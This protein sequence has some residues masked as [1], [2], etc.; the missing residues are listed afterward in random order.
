[1]PRDW[2]PGPYDLIVLSEVLY[3]LDRADL[4]SL[5]RLV[6]GSLRAD[7]AVLL[8]NWTGATDTPTTGDEA[9]QAFIG[10]V[11]PRLVV[12]LQQRHSAYRLDLLRPA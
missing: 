4:A 2:P 8:V 3:F 7:G 5:A 10:G 1:M 9:A 12:Q 6:L 11:A